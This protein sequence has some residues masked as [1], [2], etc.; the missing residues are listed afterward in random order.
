MLLVQ[1][2]LPNVHLSAGGGERA[3]AVLFVVHPLTVVNVT[4][5]EN[6][7]AGTVPLVLLEG[8][9]VDVPIGVRARAMLAVH[10]VMQVRTLVYVAARLDVPASPVLLAIQEL[11]L[12]RVAVVVRE[13]AVTSPLTA[14]LAPP[15]GLQRHD[16]LAH[17]C[18]QRSNHSSV[19]L[20]GKLASFGRV[21]LVVGGQ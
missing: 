7:P 12:V 17:L 5:G 9:A 10:L 1:S 14:V 4:R 11:P 18:R 8:A 2:P 6:I 20:H 13:E 15:A 16:G 19:R 21:R 3:D